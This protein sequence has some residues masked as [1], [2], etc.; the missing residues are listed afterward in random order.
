MLILQA[1]ALSFRYETQADPLFTDIELSLYAGEVAALLGNNGVGKTTL[2]RVLLG[3]LN[4]TAGEVTAPLA[5]VLRQEETLAA[6]ARC[7]TRCY[8]LRPSWLSFTVRYARANAP[9]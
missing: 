2:L 9:D 8:R 7:W 4:P 5:K 6:L 3:E 1:R